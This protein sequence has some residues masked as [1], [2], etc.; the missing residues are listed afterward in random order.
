MSSNHHPSSGTGQPSST[1]MH[2]KKRL[3]LLIVAP[4]LAGVVGLAF[5]LHG[6]RFVD[7]EDAYIKAQKVPV[8]ALVSG[9]I[10]EVL[11]KDNEA[12]KK[13][14]ALYNLDPAPFQI[15]VAKAEAELGKVRNDL[16]A[17][18]IGYKEK[19]SEIALART[20]Y[21][22]AVKDQHRQTDLAAKN[23]ISASKLDDVKHLTDVSSHQTLLLEQDLHRIEESLGGNPAASVERNP[24]YLASLAELERAKLDL[25][26]T[27]VRASMSGT[28]SNVPRIGQ[29]VATG[30]TTM[31]LVAN[32]VWIEANFTEAELTYVHAGQY[33]DIN[34]D[35][36]PDARLHGIVESISPATGAEFSVIP[37]QNA[38]GNWVKIA[39]RI[40]VRIKIDVNAAIPALQAGLSSWVEIDTGHKRSLFGIKF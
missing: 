18:K 22:Y 36:Y 25:S 29:F 23:F 40:P 17:T 33:V 11:V 15:A 9:A 6:G 32:D 16:A 14:Q 34:I 8:S 19:Q 3:I 4:L 28:V 20:N 24:S 27:V 7:T 13:G 12:V 21:D 30:N 31:L 35:R 37:A 2:R 38:T 39:Q 1:H 26:N 10:K 5:Y